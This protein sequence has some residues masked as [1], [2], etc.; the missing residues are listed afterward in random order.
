MGSEEEI[1]LD[2][3]SR[4]ETSAKLCGGLVVLGILLEALLALRFSDQ[5]DTFRNLAP[6]F[7][8]LLVAGGV[9]GELHFGGKRSK[10]EERL[11]E[12]SKGEVAAANERA[13]QAELATEKLR[14]QFAWRRLSPEGHK[15]MSGFLI[16]L[17]CA[18]RPAGD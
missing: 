8:N 16:L 7:A 6:V 4:F 17:W 9:W 12:M 13:T 1:L 15:L 5:K 2:S 14:A 3:V 10:T 11:R 18:G